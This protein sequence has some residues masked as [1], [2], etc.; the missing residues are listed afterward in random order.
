MLAHLGPV[1]RVTFSPD[2][3]RV[4]ILGSKDQ[5]EVYD[6]AT[7]ALQSSQSLPGKEPLSG[8]ALTPDGRGVAVV[9]RLSQ[10]VEVRDVVSGAL[11][12]GPFRHAGLV[13]ATALSPDGTRLAVSTADGSAFLWVLETGRLAVPPLQHGPSL[14]QLAF[15]GDGRRLATMGEDHTVRAWDAQTGQPLTPMLSHTEAIAWVSLAADGSRLAVRG[16]K[17]TGAVWDLS[18][19]TRPVDDLVRLTRLLSGQ[20]LDGRSGGFEPLESASLRDTWP[21]LRTKYPQEF[22]PAP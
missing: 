3:S 20:A 19:D 2:G 7:G 4:G 16:K 12:A 22:T 15:S 14:R 10:N 8:L 6:A 5:L 1:Q 21:R 18:P 17:G 13:T 11:R 9:S